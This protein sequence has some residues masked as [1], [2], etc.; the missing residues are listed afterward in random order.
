M[1]EMILQLPREM[2][3]RLHEAA[4]RHHMPVD[5][6][7]KEAIAIYLDDEDEPTNEEILANLREAMRDALAGKGRPAREVIAEI[8]AELG[9][10]AARTAENNESTQ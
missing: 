2:E 8:R 6:L 7:V 3:D 10:E 9:Y 4:E 1:S 5:E